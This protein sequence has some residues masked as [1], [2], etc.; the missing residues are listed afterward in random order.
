M[1]LQSDGLHITLIADDMPPL[2]T[3]IDAIFSEIYMAYQNRMPIL[4]ATIKQEIKKNPVTN[5]VSVSIPDIAAGSILIADN[6]NRLDTLSD[7]S[8]KIMY[9]AECY[10]SDLTMS[11]MQSGNFVKILQSLSFANHFPDIAEITEQDFISYPL[12]LVVNILYTY[13]VVQLHSA[14]DIPLKYDKLPYL[15]GN[16]KNAQVSVQFKNMLITNLSD[17]RMRQFKFSFSPLDLSFQFEADNLGDFIY[18]LLVLFLKNADK[19]NLLICPICGKCTIRNRKDAICCCSEHATQFKKMRDI[20]LLGEKDALPKVWTRARK[21]TNKMANEYDWQTA[22]DSWYNNAKA[23]YATAKTAGW[24]PTALDQK[25]KELW[26][27]Q[28]KGL[29]KK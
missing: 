21:R 25:L 15:Y 14:F 9:L 5:T 19:S 12:P 26:E 11:V 27:N 16:T 4:A 28:V 20:I 29:P 3:T 23:I 10:R 22:Y 7:L 1:I 6:S 18:L 13:W 17:F 24:K 2:D 8:D